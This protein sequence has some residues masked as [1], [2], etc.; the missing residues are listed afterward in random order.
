MAQGAQAQGVGKI[1]FWTKIGRN[2]NFII[3]REIFY[4]TESPLKRTAEKYFFR[5]K[6]RLK[7]HM[8]VFNFNVLLGRAMNAGLP[9]FLTKRDEFEVSRIIYNLYIYLYIIYIYTYII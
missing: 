3:K 6:T 4:S 2:S 9:L 7:N 1:L 8:F 5:P